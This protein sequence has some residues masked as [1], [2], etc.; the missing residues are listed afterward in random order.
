MVSAMSTPLQP[1]VT[2]SR[3]PIADCRIFRVERVWRRSGKSGLTHDFFH[4]AAGAWVNVVALTPQNEVVLVRQERHGL[5]DFTIEVPAG[6]VEPG[7]DPAVAAVRELREETGYAGG[8]AEL[9][10]VVHPNPA[11]QD[12]RC[13]MYAV[14]DVVMAGDQQLDPREEIEVLVK[15]LPEVR[16]MIRRGEITHSLVLSALY[17]LELQQR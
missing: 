15:P 4:I 10:G 5:C 11:L 6:L 2:L 3:E 12:N 7:E 13:H 14:R 1:F 8:R 9:L 16:E 17:L